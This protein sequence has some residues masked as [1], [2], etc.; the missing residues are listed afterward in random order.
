MGLSLQSL[1]VWQYWSLEAFLATRIFTG[2]F[3]GSAPV[4]KAF[5]ADL[6]DEENKEVMMAMEMEMGKC[7]TS[8][9]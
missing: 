4:A 2:V 6:G 9:Q 1:A 7:I 5:L 3:S 8:K